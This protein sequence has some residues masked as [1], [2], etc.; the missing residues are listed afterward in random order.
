MKGVWNTK[1]GTMCP[2]F[3]LVKLRSDVYTSKGK[4]NATRQC[5]RGA[6]I[7]RRIGSADATSLYRRHN[8]P[9]NNIGYGL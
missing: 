9:G 7:I 4:A 2:K 3:D 6:G 5:K 8:D 1:V